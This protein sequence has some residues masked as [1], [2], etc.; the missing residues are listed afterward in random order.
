MYL[1]CL[2]YLGSYSLDHKSLMFGTQ[3][4]IYYRSY[5]PSW[6]NT[7]RHLKR[8]KLTN[9]A[10]VP[11][12]KMTGKESA[13]SGSTTLTDTQLKFLASMMKNAKSKP[14]IDISMPYIPDGS[15]ASKR[16][17]KRSISLPMTA[18]SGITSL[19]SAA[20]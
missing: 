17:E 19:L 15:R 6:P 16:E 20:A 2:P 3:P 14:D 13:P 5:K 8:P 18:S 10:E 11:T 7:G 12:A 1:P 4:A 9:A